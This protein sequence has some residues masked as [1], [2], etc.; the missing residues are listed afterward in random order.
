VLFANQVAGRGILA[1]LSG[2]RVFS[3]RFPFEYYE[4]SCRENGGERMVCQFGRHDAIADFARMGLPNSRFVLNSTVNMNF[5]CC[6]TYPQLLCV[7]AGLGDVVF[8][9]SA[10]FRTKRRFPCVVWQSSKNGGCL[11]RSS[12]PHVGVGRARSEEDELLL[13][14][15]SDSSPTSK[16]LLICDARPRINA[17]ANQVGCATVGRFCV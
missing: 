14:T 5:Q 10:A 6:P 4:A 17:I 16:L 7:P 1:L 3:A 9:K 13:K 2:H 11:L 8:F 15:V 12:Q